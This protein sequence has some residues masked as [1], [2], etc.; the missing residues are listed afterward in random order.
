[1]LLIPIFFVFLTSV[2]AQNCLTTSDSV[3]ARQKCV[4]PFTFK[5]KTYSGCPEDLVDKERRWCSTSV[6]RTGHHIS[7]Q[8][9]YGFCSRD[10]PKFH[11]KAQRV[12]KG[13]SIR[14]LSEDS[15]ANCKTTGGPIGSGIQCQL[16][17]I[18]QNITYYGCPV[19]L[20]YDSKTWCS[21]KIDD[22]GVHV[23][24]Q[25]AYG[26]CSS[27]CPKHVENQA[28]DA[29]STC[30]TNEQCRPTI[31]CSFQFTKQELRAKI[32]KQSDGSMGTC[33]QAITEIDT[34]G[35]LLSPPKKVGFRK[36]FD[37][38]VI[39]PNL[40]RR[41]ADKG[42]SFA[43][44]VTN[45]GKFGRVKGRSSANFQHALNQ[46]GSPGIDKY[47]QASL[48]LALT[49]QELQNEVQ[50]R[51]ATFENVDLQ[52]TALENVCDR[53][54]ICNS[55]SKYR[56]ADGSC[57]NLR[58]PNYG[59]SFT[60]LQRILDPDYADGLLLPRVD[61]NGQDLPPARLVSTLTRFNRDNENPDFS[62]ILF[63]FG[64]FIDHDLD[65]V[66]IS[67]SGGEI[68]ECCTEDGEPVDLSKLTKE[69]RALCFP[70]EIPRG[71]SLARDGRRCINFVRS[72]TG[73]SLDCQPGPIQPLNQITHWLDSS[74]VY[75]STP[76]VAADLRT[77]ENGLLD[78]IIGQDG[79]EQLP[80]DPKTDCLGP[81]ET[82]GL[83]GDLRP[84]ENPALGSMHVLFL[85]EHNRV[86]RVLKELN[87]RWRDEQL[88]QESKRIV[89]AQWQHIIYNEWLPI[90]LGSRFLKTF[91]L[92]PLTQGFSS[93][94]RSDF[95]PRVTTA[96]A[97]AAF[98]VGH[99]LIP[100]V[101]R[102]MSAITS[103]AR[104]VLD[105]QDVFSDGDVIRRANAVDEIIKGLTLQAA[106]SYDNNFV[107]DITDHL[108]DDEEMGFDLIAFNIQ[109]ARDQ[110]IP[111][112]I[113]YREICGLGK[114]SNFDDLRSNIPQNVSST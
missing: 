79:Q 21:T 98:R 82:C 61:Q 54:P 103:Q 73:P 35:I 27:T 12:F 7:G 53:E 105:L 23:S 44:N 43:Q 91:G 89:N 69:E 6:N 102:T 24:G 97:G 108:F 3:D 65:H 40:V 28:I 111:G 10:C 113:H 100:D 56:T 37:G 36:V 70:L 11:A 114:V 83:A 33:C 81:T 67:T 78:T 29:P 32:C 86:A 9:K 88:Y 41:A 90:L 34:A 31:Q 77:F 4:F 42:Q 93:T 95:D 64:Q 94:Y 39:S 74:N 71:D 66:P 46:R 16:P 38:A 18:F 99:T 84:N 80:I 112:Y 110:G 22:K 2:K 47:R 60:P 1:M 76:Q 85:R 5:G 96:F 45:G 48:S 19:D 59:R 62:A 14:K 106:Q 72:V 13:K 87:P 109:R 49:A 50:T 52:D 8:G 26:Y 30:G 58:E 17:F 51:Q 15:Y 25:N 68:I 57:N 104:Q 55:R 20:V 63:S 92:Q 75:G 101:I 107:E